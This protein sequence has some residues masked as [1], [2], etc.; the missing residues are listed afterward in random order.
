MDESTKR[1]SNQPGLAFFTVKV[2]RGYSKDSQ[3]KQC[4]A[5]YPAVAEKV[6]EQERPDGFIDNVRQ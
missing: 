3:E 6:P 2:H 4:M 5:E 1:Q